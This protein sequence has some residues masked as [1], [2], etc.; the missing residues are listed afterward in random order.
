MLSGNL[1]GSQ[2]PLAVRI[3]LDLPHLMTDW[4]FCLLRKTEMASFVCL[5]LEGRRS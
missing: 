2:L 3:G 4:E 1:Q 5:T